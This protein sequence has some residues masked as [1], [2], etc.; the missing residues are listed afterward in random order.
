MFWRNIWY[1]ILLTTF[2]KKTLL[3]KTIFSAPKIEITTGASS[4]IL[5]KSLQTHSSNC[6]IEGPKYFIF[7]FFTKDCSLHTCKYIIIEK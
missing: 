7:I 3:L 5:S 6:S 4:S 2:S 1:V